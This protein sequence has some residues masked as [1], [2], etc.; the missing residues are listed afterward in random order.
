MS[1][2]PY[3]I[4]GVKMNFPHTRGVD[5]FSWGISLAGLRYR[6]VGDCKNASR[7]HLVTVK[8]HRSR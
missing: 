1:R 7:S 2:D 6:R 4:L 8:S 3:D 5:H